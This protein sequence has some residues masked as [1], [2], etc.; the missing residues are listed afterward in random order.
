MVKRKANSKSLYRTEEVYMVGQRMLLRG[1]VI[2][3]NFVPFEMPIKLAKKR[4]LQ[5]GRNKLYEKG[6]FLNEIMI[7]LFDQS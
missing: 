6:Y 4:R 3:V 2:K 7:M 5:T 1:A